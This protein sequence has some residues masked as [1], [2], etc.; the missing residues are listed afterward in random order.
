MWM[1]LYH[2]KS[3]IQKYVP[4]IYEHVTPR[5]SYV[6]RI[7]TQI[8]LEIILRIKFKIT[9]STCYISLSTS[10]C[11]FYRMC[12]KNRP[13]SNYKTISLFCA[14]QKYYLIR[15][16]FSKAIF[17]APNFLSW[18]Y[19][20]QFKALQGPIPEIINKDIR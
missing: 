16:M 18:Y 15:K 20:I 1:T 2:I 7:G 10:W 5:D 19:E 8:I 12:D 3:F 17:H 14:F 11:F 13:S 4:R 9:T 6:D